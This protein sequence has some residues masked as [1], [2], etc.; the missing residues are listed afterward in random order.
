M[1][2]SIPGNHAAFSLNEVLDATRGELVFRGAEG[3]SFVATDT[4]KLEAGSLFVALVGARFDAHRF[5]DLAVEREAC[6]LL[7]HH[8]EE[9][10]A[11]ASRLETGIVE[12]PPSIIVVGD[13]TSALG[14][15]ARHH[16]NRSSAKVVAIAGSAG[17]TT[18][19]SVVSALLERVA[20]G[21]VHSTLGNLNN[22]IGVPMTLLGLQAHHD[23][24]VVEV[25][26][27]CPG[28]V[29]ALG[30]IV[31][32]D[33]AVLTLIDLEHTEGLGD[34]DGVEAEEGAIFQALNEG[35][36]AV[37]Y[38]EDLRVLRQMQ[39]AN[40]RRFSYGEDEERD[41]RIVQRRVLGPEEASLEF[42]RRDGSIL[43]F[44]SKLIG[45]PGALAA[46]AGV[47]AV[48]CLIEKRLNSDQCQTALAMSGEPGRHTLLRLTGPRFVIDDSYNSNPASV[49][50]SVSTGNE[51]ARETGGGLWLVL[52]EM[53]ELGEL[54]EEA[55]RAMGRLARTSS[56]RGAFFVQ[57]AAKC[58]WLE[59]RK[60]LDNAHFFEAADAV[61]SAIVPLVRPQD[62]VVVKASRGVRAER[63]VEGLIAH[64][65]LASTSSPDAGEPSH[66]IPIE[67]S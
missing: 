16:R 55:H 33:V 60:E 34:L 17:K 36:T 8:C 43:S 24:A 61:V 52:G 31:R 41:L 18:T 44:R 21:R 26:T 19:R 45:K 56:P 48:E 22:R 25:G 32:A 1:A 49:A 53:L 46:A 10:K 20:P 58:A 63:V 28:E 40:A 6:I 11:L 42:R 2:T 37:G 13:T 54:S 30:Y 4:R 14:D 57:G 64:F 12:K 7:V 3:A 50:S 62:V 51:I 23:F 29:A 47:A 39:K 38:G 35:G 59:A 67:H 65:G 27:N 66:A 15:L 9:T 5:L